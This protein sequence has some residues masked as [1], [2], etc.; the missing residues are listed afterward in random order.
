MPIVLDSGRQY[1]LVIEFDI[2]FDDL[3][4][5]V[6]TKIADLPPNALIIE[7]SIVVITAFDS[8]TSDTL[9]VGTLLD[10]NRFIASPLDITALGFTALV[11]TEFISS[12]ADAE[13]H[14][15]W[16]GVGAAPT[17]GLVKVV[18]Q[19]IVDNRGNEVQPS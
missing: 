8:A 4:S 5:G 1:P 2:A 6:S 3:V 7:G 18:I 17:A 15:T 16:V 12:E 11:P 19:Y 10:P 9:D 14:A 13:I